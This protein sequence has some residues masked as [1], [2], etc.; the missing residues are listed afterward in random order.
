MW[1][2]YDELIAAVP[3][4]STISSCQLG[5]HWFLV[6]SE[7]VGVAMSPGENNAFKLDSG[8]ISGRKTRAIAEWIK[9]WNFAEAAIGLAAIN[10]ALNAP[11]LVEQRFKW[12]LRQHPSENVFPALVDEARGKKVAVVG[13]FAHLEALADLCE[14]SILERRPQPGDLP[15]SACEYILP[16]Q[17]IV[18]MT[19]TTLINKTMPRLLQLSR[20]ARV[21]LCGPSTPLSPIL[22]CYGV[23]LLGGL[24]IEN[25]TEVWRAVQEGG[26]LALF[27]QGSRMVRIPC[28]AV[29]GTS[30]HSIYRDRL[31]QSAVFHANTQ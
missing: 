27:R 15:D 3:E 17:D 11:A 25:E 14:L 2:L 8:R 12:A 4:D 16:E 21:I 24:V 1:S 6:R 22:Y 31:Q 18:V 26:D 19:A 13:H 23:D 7:G 5:L 10:S 28:A 9:S 20:N 30:R 29:A